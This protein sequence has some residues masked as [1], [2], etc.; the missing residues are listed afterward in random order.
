MY[1][2]KDK[3]KKNIASIDR[4]D[5][6]AVANSTVCLKRSMKQNFEFVDNRTK[7]SIPQKNPCTQLQIKMHGKSYNQGEFA[8]AYA[9]HFNIK[10]WDI[11]DLIWNYIEFADRRNL[12]FN[13]YQQVVN[14]VLVGANN[15]LPLTPIY[16][17][18]NSRNT[19]NMTGNRAQ[20][21]MAANNFYPN[22][23][24]WDWHHIEGI[25][26]Q[27]PNWKCDMILV[28][29]VHHSQWHIGAVHQWEQVIGIKYT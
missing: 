21:K 13:S 7:T 11:P 25:T 22:N 3:L 18:A 8:E 27:Y 10:P 5:S 28:N 16:V 6:R 2:Q 19:I 17:I 26:F 1:T 20:D 14:Q 29:P 24:G 9:K 4:R 23:I 15:F 12:T